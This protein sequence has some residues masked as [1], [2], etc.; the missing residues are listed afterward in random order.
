MNLRALLYQ[1]ALILGDFNA[2]TNLDA[3]RIGR[4]KAHR[5]SGGFWNKW[6]K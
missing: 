4:K 3:G 2:V 6:I 1:W 5:T